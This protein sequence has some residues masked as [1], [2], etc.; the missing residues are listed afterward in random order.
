MPR[1][2]SQSPALMPDHAFVLQIHAEARLEDGQIAGRVEHLV[3]RRA[4]S[5]QSL[6][7]LLLFMAQVLRDVRR[8]EGSSSD[9]THPID[10]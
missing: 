7:A 8:A 6:D 10:L 9:L 1:D 4:A 5:F 2:T 3:S